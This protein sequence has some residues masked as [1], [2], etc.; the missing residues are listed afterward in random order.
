MIIPLLILCAWATLDVGDGKAFVRIE[1]AVRAAHPGDEIRVFPKSAGYPRTA[2]LIRTAGLKIVGQGRIKIDGS[3]FDYSGVGS[4]P[5]AIFQVDPSADGVDIE[6]F[7]LVGANNAS[8]NGAGLRINAAN[9][10]TLRNCSVHGNNMGIMSSGSVGDAR[11]GSNQIIDHCEIYGNGDFSDPGYNHNLYLGGTSVTI[12]FCDIH[13]SLTGHNIKSRAHFTVVQ[14]CSVHDS[15]NREMDFVDA[16]DT[17][18]PCS[19]VVLIGNVIRKSPESKGNRTVIHFGVEKGERD[20]TIYLINND[21]FTPFASPVVQM[22][23]ASSS[24]QFFQNRIE[25]LG[26]AH[27]VFTEG[28]VFGSGN[29]ISPNYDLSRAQFG[30]GSPFFVDGEGKRHDARPIYRHSKGTWMPTSE[31][32]VGAG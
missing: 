11:A 27:P 12:Q 19:N 3:G 24:S 30:T 25:C 2:V 6:N 21:I 20:G 17:E 15:A 23:S 31:Q 1:D 28:A 8:H 4:V 5:R 9:R 32:F 26:Q 7:E 14:Y 22:T 16:W 13:D 29:V 10:C 18:R